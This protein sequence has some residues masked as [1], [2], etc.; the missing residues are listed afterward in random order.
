M[1]LYPDVQNEARKEIDR[2]VGSERLP[3]WTDRANLSY[4]RRCVEETLRCDSYVNL[5]S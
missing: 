5:T 2:V 4:V 3:D 1:T